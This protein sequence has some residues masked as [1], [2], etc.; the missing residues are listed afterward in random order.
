MAGK[1]GKKL[2]ISG[3]KKHII[4][5]IIMSLLLL[6]FFS[7]KT[8]NNHKTI[9]KNVRFPKYSG[10]WYP[11][12]ESQLSSA[13]DRYFKNSEDHGI[14][15]IKAL[16][17]PHAGYVYSGQVASN[18]FLQLKN[19]YDK[20]IIIASNHNPESP[21]FK[22]STVN[23]THY[24]TPLGQVP[25]S[26]ITSRLLKNELFDFIEKAHENHMIELELPFLQKKLSDFKIVPIITGNINY[27]EI[28]DT[29]ELINSYIDKNTLLVISS[30]LS[31]YHQYGEAVSL[32]K[33]CIK[34]IETL[35]IKKAE[36]CEACGLSGILILL[37]ISK[38]NNWDAKIINY[39]NSGDVSG[40]KSSV[41]GYS[42]IVFYEPDISKNDKEF[43][44]KLSR[45][46][47]EKY[48]KETKIP[49][50]NKNLISERLLK[51]QGCFVTLNKKNNLRGCIGHIMPQETLYECVIDNTINAAVNDRRFSLVQEHELDEIEI[52]ISA[53]SVP[54]RLDYKNPE[55][56]LKQL[57]PEKH[58]VIVKSGLH[59][60]TYLPQV[61]EELPEKKEF[62][63]R[64][65][66]KAGLTQYCW[67]E[68][69]NVLTYTASV[70]EE[71]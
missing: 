38:L 51:K 57:I 61:W 35:N 53:L 1:R 54:E 59:Q 32:D 36:D 60:A 22:I 64:L 27:D 37:E 62:L 7:I 43:L 67:K 25:V 56:L 11:E 15:K 34:S 16:I 71:K 20:V 40:D 45:E 24:K 44:L 2:K 58:G 6:L 28:K 29:A 33:E 23:Y 17:V 10:S 21:D 47:L 19:D 48:I 42:S 50:I 30:D 31:H 9:E 68:N 66:I 4:F 14:E 52:E 55:D 26:E 5:I 3:S 39:K 63:Q 8:N 70:W 13:I 46:T 69:I 65:C 12:T 41:V 49:K 18:G